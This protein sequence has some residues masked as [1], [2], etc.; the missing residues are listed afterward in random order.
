MMK[1]RLRR[2]SRRATGMVEGTLIT[3]EWTTVTDKVGKA[4][5]KIGRRGIL[6]YEAQSDYAEEEQPNSEEATE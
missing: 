5:L 4:A 1:I 3:R 2:E 6:V